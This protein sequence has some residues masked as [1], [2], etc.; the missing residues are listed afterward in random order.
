MRVD[1]ANDSL[2]VW[3]DSAKG[4]PEVDVVLTKIRP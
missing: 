3:R 4:N 2:T 1:Y